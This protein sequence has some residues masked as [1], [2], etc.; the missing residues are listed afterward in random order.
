ML[1][2]TSLIFTVVLELGNEEEGCTNKEKGYTE[3][4]GCTEE[5]G[6]AEEE[7]CDKK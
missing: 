3:E 2:Q 4:E 6:C 5:K 7:N 1:P